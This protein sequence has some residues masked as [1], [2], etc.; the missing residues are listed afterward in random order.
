M[1]VAFITRKLRNLSWRR[2]RSSWKILF[3]SRGER[4][5]ARF[6]SRRKYRILAR[7]YRCA[8]GEIDLIAV[9]GD[10]L[11]FVE[12]K[13]RSDDDHADAQESVRP[14]KWKRV[15][16]AARFFLMETHAQHAA[17]RFD[18]I[19]ILWPPGGSPQIEQFE[20]AYEP[21]SS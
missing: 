16:R 1:N 20:S 14:I 8:V 13:T 18:L 4:L 15:H 7:N 21:R 10:M 17:C 3:G 11:V 2:P 6:L 5:A 12:V 19:T 9:D